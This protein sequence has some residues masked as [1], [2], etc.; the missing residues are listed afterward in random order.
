[1]SVLKAIPF[2][3]LL[4]ISSGC[5]WKSYDPDNS[6]DYHK[7]W[8]EHRKDSLLYPHTEEYTE[9]TEGKKAPGK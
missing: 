2:A 3:C 8:Q 7:Y 6:D 1:M 5:F 4:M 9:E